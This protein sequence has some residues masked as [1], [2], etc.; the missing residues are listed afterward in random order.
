MAFREVTGHRTVIQLISRAVRRG[1]LPPSLLFA[2]PEGVGKRTV[3]TAL[4]QT[5]N[6]IS[7][8]CDSGMDACG[9]CP[10]CCRIAR[11]TYPDVLVI[12]PDENGAILID[13][14]R[15]AVG[16]AMYR[17]F[18]GRR[19]V[20]IIDEADCLVP[21]AQNALLKTLEE[22]PNSTQF[23]IVTARPDTLFPTVRSRCQRLSFGQLRTSDVSEVLTRDHGYDENA[24]HEAAESGGGS[25]GRALL[26]ASGELTGAHE[27]AVRLLEVIASARDPK[28]RLDGAKELLVGKSAQSRRGADQ[29]QE[30]ERRLRALASVLRDVTL[31]TSGANEAECANIDLRD[32]LESTMRTFTPARGLEAF[33]VVDEALRAVE[34][35]AGLRLVA[36]WVACRL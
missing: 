29:R 36:D 3:A 11:G 22:P 30:L 31:V 26:L 15:Q 7:P 25:V 4:A 2:G 5:L 8:S 28:K 1:S 24:A 6:C 14:I 9:T 20:I 18:E 27:A 19:R 17:P 35:N 13:E 23:V 16:Q 34:R 33:G 10:T 32:R 12:R 21:Q